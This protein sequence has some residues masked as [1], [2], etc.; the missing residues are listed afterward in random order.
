LNT[1][2]LIGLNTR[3][4]AS[5]LNTTLRKHQM[6]RSLTY[7][8]IGSYSTLKLKQKHIGNSIRT[9]IGFSEN[10]IKS[11]VNCYS[12]LNPS[13]FY[14]FES[15]RMKHGLFLQNIIRFIGKKLFTKTLRGER[16]GVVHSNISTLN[17]A[18]LG[19]TSGVRSPLHVDSIKDKEIATLFLVQVEDFKSEK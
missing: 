17:C 13:I 7:V 8:T 1:L 14:G 10:K 4:E 12:G 6:N 19:K 11:I 2:L 15:T 18:H 5:L 9:L 3:F 16:L